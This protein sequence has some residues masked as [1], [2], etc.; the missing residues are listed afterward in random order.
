MKIW[1]RGLLVGFVS[2][3]VWYAMLFTPA[4]HP[5]PFGLAL[6]PIVIAAALVALGCVLICGWICERWLFQGRTLLAAFVAF[7]FG[8]VAT[9][10]VSRLLEARWFGEGFAFFGIHAAGLGL[11]VLVF[12]TVS[13]LRRKKPNHSTEPLSP[14]RGGSS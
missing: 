4:L 2:G 3:V 11:P 13:A 5:D 1:R 14:S 9:V 7:F 12:I 10:I 8:L 6:A